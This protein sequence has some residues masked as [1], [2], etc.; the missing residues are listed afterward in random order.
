MGQKHLIKTITHSWRVSA[1]IMK[2]SKEVSLLNRLPR[3][4][5]GRNFFAYNTQNYTRCS[6]VFQQ[7]QMFRQ[8]SDAK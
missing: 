1:K 8:K 6:S 7:V 4:K 3:G 5:E 2:Q